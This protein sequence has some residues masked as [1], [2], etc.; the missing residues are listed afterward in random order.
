MRKQPTI[1]DVA[2]KC[3]YSKST[4]S[5]VLQDSPEIS[6]ST[7]EEVLQA[8]KQI[9]YRQNRFARSLRTRKSQV[10]GMMIQDHLNPFYS[11][12]VQHVER[13]LREKG[14]DL[15]VS[16]SNTD[17]DME[18]QVLERLSGMQVDGIII[19]TM[20]YGR[21]EELLKSIQAGGTYCVIAGATQ[22]CIPFDVVTINDQEA[23]RAAMKHLFDFGHRSIG[24]IW[25]APEFQGIGGR[26]Q[27]FR[28][29]LESVGLEVNE[30]WVKHCGYQ[31]KDGYEAAKALFSEK[32]RPTAVFA[33]NDLLALATIRAVTDLG[34]R[35]PE[36]VS[37][38]GYDNVEVSK[39]IC[40]S[41][42]TVSLPIGQYA[43]ALTDL[44]LEGVARKRKEKV[45]RLDCE[46]VFSPRE[47]TGRVSAC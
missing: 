40:P 2:K 38:V 44:V 14:Y 25:G 7:K 10:V 45:R 43:H 31:L 30:A 29:E 24:F 5:L 39:Y 34:M 21:I 23:M 4:V 27:I 19:S 47:S 6:A 42:T 15:I 13:R 18:I 32:K 17:L 11:E 35:V 28:E 9:G 22:P 16:S 26:F 8:M 41:L 20:A 46:A 36:D 12:I 1:H 33:L 3:G 37:V